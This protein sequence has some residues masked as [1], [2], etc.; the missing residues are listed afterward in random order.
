M[1]AEFEY[2]GKTVQF[3]LHKNRK[4]KIGRHLRRKGTFWDIQ[5]LETSLQYLPKHAV[6]VDCGSN[7]GN[8]VV[9]WCLHGHRVIAIEPHPVN[10]GLLKKNI[11]LNNSDAQAHKVLLSDCERQY[12]C[13]EA[14]H[15]LMKVNFKLSA[16]GK[17]RSATLDE[18]VQ[19]HVDFIKIDVEG[20]E[21]E[22]LKGA[23]KILSQ[24]HP[25]LFIEYHPYR[26]EFILDKLV[27]YLK[28]FKYTQGQDVLFHHC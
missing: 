24:Y 10:F 7:I 3:A 13:V 12:N 26:D 20:S 21:L 16:S 19:G 4:D 1:K 22:V 18:T 14:K 5:N 15:N 8:H 25:L 11:K 17:F 28:I 27:R 2:Q 23:D 6:V 9:F